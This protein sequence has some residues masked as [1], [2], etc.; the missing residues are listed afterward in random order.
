MSESPRKGG[1]LLGEGG[2]ANNQATDEQLG[3]VKLASEL[4]QNEAKTTR[5]LIH[6]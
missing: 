2:V 3:N 1:V 4:G 5:Q 6:I